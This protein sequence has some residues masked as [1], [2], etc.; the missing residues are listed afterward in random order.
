MCVEQKSLKLKNGVAV[1]ERHI[2]QVVGEKHCKT[3][4]ILDSVY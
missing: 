3:Q 2:L 1:I 4:I